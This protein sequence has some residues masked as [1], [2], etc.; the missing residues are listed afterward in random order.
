EFDALP[1]RERIAVD[2]HWRVVHA[3]GSALLGWLVLQPRRHVMEVSDLTDAEAVAL[4]P[5]QT[6]L[7]RALAAETGASKTYISSYGEMPGFHLHF[8]V[9]PRPLDLDPSLRGPNSFGLLGRT[10]ETGEVDEATR[11]AFAE[12]L[13][14]RLR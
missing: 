11:D 2:E 10:P 9:A 3:F 7:A 4:G 5:W 12:R 6:R 14:V 13:A 1:P 8:H